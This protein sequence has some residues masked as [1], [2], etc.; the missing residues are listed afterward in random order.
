MHVNTAFSRSS[1]PELVTEIKERCVTFEVC[2]TSN[3][4]RKFKVN[5]YFDHPVKT[6][7]RERIPFTLSMDN[8]MLSGDEENRPTPAGEVAHFV[9]DVIK[10]EGWREAVRFSLESGLKAA[11]SPAV[12]GSFK[13]AFMARVDEVLQPRPLT[14]MGGTKGLQRNALV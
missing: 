5:S 13:T 1:P 6:M 10:D 7:W 8:W 12:T 3:V 9:N 2:L 4:A 11:F 14:K